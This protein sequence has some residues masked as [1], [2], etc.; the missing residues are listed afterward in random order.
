[1]AYIYLTQR[2]ALVIGKDIQMVLVLYNMK[3]II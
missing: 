3:Q 2:A 1:M